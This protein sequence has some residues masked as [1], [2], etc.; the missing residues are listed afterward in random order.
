MS[1]KH[2]TKATKTAKATKKAKAAKPTT[3][4]ATGGRLN[5][6]GALAR[7]PAAQP[8]PG[9]ATGPVLDVTAA[10]ARLTGTVPTSLQRLAY[11]FEYGP[12]T[13]YGSQTPTRRNPAISPQPSAW[14]RLLRCEE[15]LRP[16]P[17]VEQSSLFRQCTQKASS[18]RFPST[19]SCPPTS[20]RSAVR[21]P[22][23][24]ASGIRERERWN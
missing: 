2:S 7:V 18:C 16:S 21:F 3:K 15:P 13:A 14:T 4:V 12:T 22:G 23:R 19:S 9:G 1:K 24:L 20:F 11:H 10:G 17:A 8:G 6:P 5:A